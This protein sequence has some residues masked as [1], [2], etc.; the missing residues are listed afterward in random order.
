MLKADFAILKLEVD[1]LDLDKL[2]TVPVDLRKLSN[3]V[4]N[5]VVKR[6][7]FDKLVNNIN[8]IDTNG[9]KNSI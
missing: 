6:A 4:D 9:F 2:K 1:K 7:V 3:I 5:G 8:A